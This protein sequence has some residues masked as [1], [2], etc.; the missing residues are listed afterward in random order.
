MLSFHQ[1]LNSAISLIA[2][3]FTYQK[4][5]PWLPADITWEQSDMTRN[6]K[7]EGALFILFS[8]SRLLP[9]LFR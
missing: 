1:V 9:P 7:L 5:F 6:L 4:Y 8:L 2:G 3:F